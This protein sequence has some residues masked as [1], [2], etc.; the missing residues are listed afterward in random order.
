MRLAAAQQLSSPGAGAPTLARAER[1]TRVELSTG[2]AK[3]R[4][5]V[6]REGEET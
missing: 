2:F 3:F 1:D 4:I 6:P 5:A